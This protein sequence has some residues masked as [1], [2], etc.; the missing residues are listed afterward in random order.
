MI[1]TVRGTAE[2]I[3]D[4]VPLV[5]RSIRAKLHELRAADINVH[6]FRAMLYINRNHGTSLSDVA[7]HVGVSLPTMSVLIDKLVDR[8]LVSRDARGGE[9][10]RR[11]MC[12]FL[13]LQ[14][15][16]E[17]NVAYDFAQKF[18]MVKMSRLSK[19]ELKTI[20]QAMQI[21]QDLFVIS[22]EK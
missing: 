21:L 16:E 1:D 12:L 5:M 20:S 6:Q 9:E 4:V 22:P 11:K 3:I 8:K 17:L 14:G 15:Q 19:E 13:T 7:A 10:D 18:L 2:R